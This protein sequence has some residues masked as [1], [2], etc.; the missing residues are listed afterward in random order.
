MRQ[1]VTFKQLIIDTDFNQVWECIARHYD[2]RSEVPSV[3]CLF[4]QS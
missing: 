2:V 4:H 1:M 3:V